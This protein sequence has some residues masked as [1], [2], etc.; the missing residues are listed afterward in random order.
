MRNR[1]LGKSCRNV[2][3]VAKR[4]TN[5]KTIEVHITSRKTGKTVKANCK[6]TAKYLRAL[7]IFAM[8]MKGGKE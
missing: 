8:N 6:V 3:K 5:A 4:S 7:M 1:H 2:I